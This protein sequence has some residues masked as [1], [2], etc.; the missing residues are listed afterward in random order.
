DSVFVSTNYGTGCALLKLGPKTMS[1]VYFSNEMKNHYSTSVLIDGYLYGYNDSILTAMQFSSGKVAWKD[2]S[3]G[4]GS[5]TYAD[6]HL[7]LLSE[8]GML[9]LADPAPESYKEISRFQ[10]SKGSLPTWSP[11]VI[12]DA[13]MYFRDQDNL[14]SFDIK[15]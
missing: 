10:I 5:V 9:G 1:E 15:K 6:K 8:N 7:Y 13:K 14:T 3:V 12:S 4:K 11:L 2:R